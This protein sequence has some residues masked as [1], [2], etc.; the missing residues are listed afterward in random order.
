MME[1]H[2]L[3]KSRLANWRAYYELCKP[4]VVALMMLTTVVGMCLATPGM[5]PWNSL[6]LGNLGIALA[7]GAAAVINQLVDS[8]IDALM[9]RTKQRP[10]PTGKVSTK[11][12][13]WFALS[14][15]SIGIGILIVW[16]NVL[17]ALLTL[18]T[19]LGYAVV[20]TM[21]LK[22]ATPQNIVIGGLAGATPPLLGWVAVTGQFDPNSLL[23]VLIIYAWTPPHFWALA[24]HREKEY[25]NANIPMLPV[26]HGV[27]LTKIH[28][29]LYTL[30]MLAASVMPFITR[31]SGWI[32]LAGALLLGG[33]FVYW[34]IRLLSDSD[35]RIPMRTFRFSIVYLMGIFIFLLVDH[36]WRF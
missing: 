19:L 20:Y 8:R 15:G 7:A 14:I 3:A 2:A 16:V 24:I 17:T 31:M 13:L 18:V 26:T 29:V 9:L 10:I 21:F 6:I 27:K 36:Y 34:S 35:S 12:A 28:I 4:R 22:R 25:A 1:T 33:R 5:V 30:L 23:L 32:Y 11:H